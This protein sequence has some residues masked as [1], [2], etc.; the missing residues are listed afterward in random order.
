MAKKKNKQNWERN[1]KL[2][3]D[4]SFINSIHHFVPDDFEYF[5]PEWL[6]PYIDEKKV[7]EIGWN[8]PLAL[9]ECICRLMNFWR[10]E[11]VTL[12]NNGQPKKSYKPEVA[13]KINRKKGPRLERK[14]HACEAL[15]ALM[16]M[17]LKPD[18]NR[19]DENPEPR[20]N[21]EIE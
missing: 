18:F 17:K 19:L 10:I 6:Q 3:E 7:A 14:K 8:P 2:S 20:F 15:M 5:L 11:Y 16:G 21:Y 4:T 13:E 1:I 9:K 12:Q